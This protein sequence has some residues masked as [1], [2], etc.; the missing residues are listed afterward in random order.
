MHKNIIY[1]YIYKLTIYYAK[2]LNVLEKNL[3]INSLII[4]KIINIKLKI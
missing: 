2:I 1:I 4:K 3:L